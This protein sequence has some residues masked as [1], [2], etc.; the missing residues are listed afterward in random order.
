MDEIRVFYRG[1]MAFEAQARQHRLAI[2][3][4]QE[5]GGTDSAMTPPEIF[6]ASLGSCVGVYV[7]KYCERARL[8]TQ[9]MDIR[10]SWKLAADNKSIGTIDIGLSL[11]HAEVGKR[12]AALL[13]VAR[14]CLIHETIVRPPDIRISF[15]KG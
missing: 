5:K 10:V 11:P 8:D 2:D 14:H 7:A 12:E 1:K 4:S 3:L 15:D 13:E 6:A 9:D